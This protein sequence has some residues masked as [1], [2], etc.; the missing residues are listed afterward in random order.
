MVSPTFGESEHP[1]LRPTGDPPPVSSCA[2]EERWE[3]LGKSHR[4]AS[5]QASTSSTLKPTIRSVG[6]AQDSFQVWWASSLSTFVHGKQCEKLC[7]REPERAKDVLMEKSVRW[8]VN[9]GDFVATRPTA[10]LVE[11]KNKL[12]GVCP[13]KDTD[14]QKASNVLN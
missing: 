2:C 13:I 6:A 9:G 8:R 12:P 7:A 3:G 1:S 14:Q 4:N 11:L 5:V 10:K